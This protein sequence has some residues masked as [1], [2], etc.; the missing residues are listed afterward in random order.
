MR[1]AGAG[2]QAHYPLAENADRRSDLAD[3]N[4]ISRAVAL[5]TQ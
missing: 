3:C 4:S 2:A 5:L 1:P